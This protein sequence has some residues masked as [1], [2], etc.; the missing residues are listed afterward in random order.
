MTYF[1]M[2]SEE[3][4]WVAIATVLDTLA[5]VG[6]NGVRLP[7]FPESDEVKGPNP[8][9]GSGNSEIGWEECNQFAINIA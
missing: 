9:F 8:D 7:M 3:S 1:N 2:S 6:F 5:A 4:N